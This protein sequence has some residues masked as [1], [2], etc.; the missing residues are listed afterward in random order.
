MDIDVR[1]N[2]KSLSVAVDNPHRYD[3]AGI[4]KDIDSFGKENGVD[5]APFE[6]E[7]LI[8][9]MI[10]GVAGCEA[11]CPSDAMGVV[12]RGF[13]NFKLSYVEGG[14]L[15]AVQSLENGVPLEVKIFPEFG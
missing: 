8:P 3:I 12:R 13:G 15:T 11:G 10:R 7:R 4:I 9:V 5:L 1:I 2:G 6:L 14:I